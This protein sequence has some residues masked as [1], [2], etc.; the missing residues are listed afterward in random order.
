MNATPRLSLS[1]YGAAILEVGARGFAA[2]PTLQARLRD[3]AGSTP[4]ASLGVEYTRLRFGEV[5]GDGEDEIEH[6]LSLVSGGL[7]VNSVRMY[8]DLHVNNVNI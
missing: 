6:L 2:V 3:G 1:L 4:F 5:V 7:H 8:L